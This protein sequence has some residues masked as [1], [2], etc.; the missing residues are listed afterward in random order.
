MLEREDLRWVLAVHDAGSLVGAA[1][2]LGVTAAA[3]TKRLAQVEKRLGLKLFARS[4]RA[5]S[6]T[7]EGELCCRHARELLNSFGELEARL[8]DHQDKPAGAVHLA[9]NAGFGRLWLGPLIAEFASTQPRVEV[10]VHL[11]NRLPDLR[12]EG[13]DAALW[14]WPGKH[15]AYVVQTL[16]PHKRVL[17]AAPAYLRRHGQPRQ[18]ADLAQHECLLM[19]ERD[20]PAPIWRL[21]PDRAR[22]KAAA[23]DVPVSGRLSSNSGELIRDW[24]LAGHGIAL[25]PVWDVAEHLQRRRLQR[26]LPGWA[27][28]DADI[29]WIAPFRA[30]VPARVR[31]LQQFLKERLSAAPWLKA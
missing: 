28:L 16:A 27:R 25:R 12:A 23:V 31:L 11:H 21:Q 17:V 15:D 3:V 26:V 6:T 2:R 19:H 8:A 10:S 1:N 13:Y 18:P 22:S 30:H 7:D 20:V 29:Q 14:L 9:A 24:C 5:L 4:T